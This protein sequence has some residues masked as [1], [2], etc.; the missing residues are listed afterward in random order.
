MMKYMKLKNKIMIPIVILVFL[1]LS[2]I[3]AGMSVILYNSKSQD[4]QKEIR[5]SAKNYGLEISS[6]IENSF[7][8]ARA[9][10]SILKGIKES[11]S[12]D[13]KIA[14][15]QLKKIIEDSSEF[16]FGI[17]S[18]WEPDMF[19]GKDRLFKGAAAH[20]ETG[21]YIPYWNRGSGK[22]AL[23]ATVDYGIETA[24]NYYYMVKTRAKEV[25]VEPAEY[26][27][28]GKKMTVV[29]LEVPI[30]EDSKVAG[31]TGIDLLL[32]DIINR[33]NEIKPYKTGYGYLVSNAGVIIA[34]PNSELIGKNIKEVFAE[35]DKK[36]EISSSIADGKELFIERKSAINKEKVYEVL[37]PV[38]TGNTGTPWAI[39][40]AIPKSVVTNEVI[41]INIIIAVIG[42]A[43]LII[44][45]AAIAIISKNVTAPIEKF[46]AKF[47]SGANGDLTVRA[48]IDGKDEIGV[49][50]EEFNQFMEKLE[51]MIL[52]IK[53]GAFTIKQSSQ[54]INRANESLANKATTQASALE[55]ISS[56]M[57]EISSIVASNT[58]TISEVS[59]IVNETRE[60]TEEV[61]VMSGNLKKSIGE[62][63]ESSKK[64]RNIIEVIDEIAFQTNLLALNA[65]V[66]AARAG[67]QGI[68]FAVVAVEVRNLAARSSK[69]AKEIKE[70]IKESGDR[71]D[72]GQELV[73]NTIEIEKVNSVMSEISK[74]A[75]EQKSGIEQ[76]NS[77]IMSLDEITQTNAGIAEETSASSNLL[78]EKAENFNEMID[79]FKVKE[80]SREKG[81]REYQEK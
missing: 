16:V 27:I 57:E 9:A 34:H 22:I 5:E 58:D 70:L 36:Y 80:N 31:V 66:E 46:V 68:G 37:L 49:M 71:V 12:A 76:V 7:E 21:R 47:D 69:A 11:G 75:A 51:N 55:E 73:G 53:E 25:I 3:I 24:D 30:I 45:M 32:G 54:E 52:E 29:S 78:S 63:S 18:V 4:K 40:I 41:K 42:I 13:R 67:E 44:I 2:V 38:K 64:I 77:S 35:D 74:A 8:K 48:D 60:R 50:S 1:I 20:D 39:G 59:R 56:T 81:I 43:G 61:G 6:E 62:I 33:I 23:E 26:T 28:A 14:T 17:W 72:K 19:D 15:N 65:A 79:Y 10:A